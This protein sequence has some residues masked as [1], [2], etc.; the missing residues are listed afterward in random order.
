VAG[1][2]P[3]E[4]W[5]HGSL[6][7]SAAKHELGAL[8]PELDALL[9]QHA[10]R[11]RL[12]RGEQLYALG[13]SPD[14]FF[15]VE[16]G[17]IRLSV[18]SESGREAVLALVTRGQWFGEASLFAGEPRGNDAVSIVPSS[19]LIVSAATLQSLVN[20]RPD[21]LLQFLAMIGRRYR[22]VMTRM[23]DTVLRPLPVRLARVLVQAYARERSAGVFGD[24]VTLPLSQ[25]E[26]AH[27][28]G[29]SRQ[30]VNRLLKHWEK[31]GIVRIG[32][33]SLTIV[34]PENLQ[35]VCDAE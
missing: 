23:D 21:Y 27:M 9:R 28:L 13:S 4:I 10:R 16:K 18:T 19:V 12:A 1:A 22:A 34:R 6:T 5:G 20:D 32:Y 8:D 33:R 35:A 7:D 11:R 24:P 26:L 29:G 17:T 30:S 2:T 31:E 14:A 3:A 15:C 25:E